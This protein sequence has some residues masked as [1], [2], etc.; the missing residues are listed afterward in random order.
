LLAWLNRKSF[1]FACLLAYATET[2]KREIHRRHAKPL[3]VL[4]LI[5]ALLAYLPILNL[6]TPGFAA[7]AYIHY[8]LEALR[9]LRGGAY[10]SI[11]KE[12]GEKT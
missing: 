8:C 2:E 1:V 12:S 6:L 4:G 7:L 9:Q 3:F 10:A 5:L 11:Q